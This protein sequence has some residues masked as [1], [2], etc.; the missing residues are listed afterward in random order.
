MNER[1]E[2]FG[3]ALQRLDEA[4]KAQE[5][6]LNRDASIQRFEFCVELAWKAMQKT[7]EEEKILCNSP[8]SCLKEA[9]QIGLV[10]DDAGW[11]H[12]LDDRNLTVHTYKQQLA[13]EIYGRLGG[14]LSLLQDLHQALLRT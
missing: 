5:T 4:L 1:I 8:K 10:Q 14:Y 3:Q 11:L 6:D 9:F 12:M 2:S 13:Q 7:L